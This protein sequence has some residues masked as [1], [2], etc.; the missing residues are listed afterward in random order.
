MTT[1]PAELP[2]I[3]EL[4]YLRRTATIVNKLEEEKDQDGDADT[5]R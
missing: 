3:A 2:D 4:D 5:A 1:H